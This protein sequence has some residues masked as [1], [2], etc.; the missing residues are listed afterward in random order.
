M[1]LATNKPVLIAPAM[2]PAMWSHAATKRNRATLAKDGIH[3]IG[4][5]K[6]EM[7]ESGEAGEGRMAEPLE[8]VAAIEAL[9]D[10]KAKTACGQEDHRHIRPDA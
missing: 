7:A 2:N 4:P 5:N 3:F 1:L 6:G 8:I 10:G 9:L